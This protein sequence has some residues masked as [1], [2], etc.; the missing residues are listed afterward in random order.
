VPPSVNPGHR[1]GR[2]VPDVSGDA[3]PATGYLVVVG[4]S[5]VVVGGTSAVSPLWS[6]LTALLN[7]ALGKRVGFLNPLLYAPAEKASF[8]DVTSGGNG[9]YSAGPGW[10]ACTGLGTPRGQALLQALRGG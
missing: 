9:G 1:V 4:G 6:G 2:G 10:D 5:T 8:G 7:E 3:D